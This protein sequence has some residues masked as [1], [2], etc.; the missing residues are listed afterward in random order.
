MKTSNERS[1]PRLQDCIDGRQPALPL[2][3]NDFAKQKVYMGNYNSGQRTNRR[4]T[5]DMRRLDVRKLQKAGML[6]AGQSNGWRWWQGGGQTLHE[7]QIEAYPDHVSI[8]HACTRVAGEQGSYRIGIERTACHLGGHRVWWRCP[9]AGCSRRVAVLYGCNGAI[10]ACRHCYRL[11]YKCQRETDSN[12]LIRR[13][14]KLRGRL[15]WQP[16]F[17][18]GDKGKPHRMRWPTYW[19]LVQ[20]HDQLEQ[21]IL[22]SA[23]RRFRHLL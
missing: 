17:G 7:A 23:I 9:A 15:G 5:A 10:F 21:A 19:R 1:K 3:S 13:L 6:V 8:A 11:N 22:L 2:W 18:N 14:D 12:R 4:T 16:G 20:E